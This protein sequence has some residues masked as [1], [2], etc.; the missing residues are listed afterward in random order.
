MTLRGICPTRTSQRAMGTRQ[1]L[2]HYSKDGMATSTSVHRDHCSLCTVLAVFLLAAFHSVLPR[3]QQAPP[4]VRVMSASANAPISD[5]LLADDEIVVVTRNDNSVVPVPEP[6]AREVVDDAVERSDVIAIVEIDKVTGLLVEEGQWIETRVGGRVREVLK[7]W[8]S[9]EISPG[10]ALEWHITGGQLMI[11][12]ILVKAGGVFA[13]QEGRPY[14]MFLQANSLT[15][16]LYPVHL[17]LLVEN[18][19]LVDPRQV[20][21]GSTARD[22]L[23]DLAFQEIAEEVRRLTR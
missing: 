7:S 10:R 4:R 6:S 15:G 8:N 18:G 1:S 21:Q 17:P 22:P 3:A 2:H 20:E 19:R 16:V 14:L 9:D 13:L 23:H 12:K 11:G 5:R